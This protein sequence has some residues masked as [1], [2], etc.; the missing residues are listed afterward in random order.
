MHYPRIPRYQRLV[1]KLIYISHTRVD[2]YMHYPHLTHLK[3]NISYPK[4]SEMCPTNGTTFSI[5]A[6][7]KLEAFKDAAL[8]IGRTHLMIRDLHRLH[9]V[10]R[11][12][13]WPIDS[14]PLDFV[15]CAE[16]EKEMEKG[17]KLYPLCV[18]VVFSPQKKRNSRKQEGK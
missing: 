5:N 10:G 4:V 14:G 16:V 8:L 17:E 3:G 2:R 15:W 13:Y 6:H 18:F 11:K 9:F 1:G 12:C 7:L